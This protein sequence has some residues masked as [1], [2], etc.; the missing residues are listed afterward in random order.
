MYR[1]R[2]ERRVIVRLRFH[3][4]YLR[5]RARRAR[6]RRFTAGRRLRNALPAMVPFDVSTSIFLVSETTI[7][8]IYSI[9]VFIRIYANLEGTSTRCH[10]GISTAINRLRRRRRARPPPRA[11]VVGQI[12]NCPS[13]DGSRHKTRFTSLRAA[14]FTPRPIGPASVLA[15]YT[16]SYLNGTAITGYGFIDDIRQVYLKLKA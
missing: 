2:G 8:N 10:K 12:S 3:D 11:R 6:R 16:E 7:L 9:F 5:R 14:L 4:F 15:L 1:G 13:G